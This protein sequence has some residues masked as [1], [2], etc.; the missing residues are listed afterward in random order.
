M[1]DI[2]MT[3]GMAMPLVLTRNASGG[4]NMFVRKSQ[5]QQPHILKS[6]SD[7]V[8]V[9]VPIL[10]SLHKISFKSWQDKYEAHLQRLVMSLRLAITENIAKT[11]SVEVD[12]DWQAFS[13]RVRRLA[14][15]HSTSS[16]KNIHRRGHGDGHVFAHHGAPRVHESHMNQIQSA[17]DDFAGA[18]DVEFAE[19]ML[20]TFGITD[21]HVQEESHHECE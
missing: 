19:M 13:Q 8:P 17:I 11:P 14:Y 18:N 6:I 7:Q 4:L 2:D 20:E 3:Q 1:F 21:T 5:A 15:Q 9:P 16:N 12:V 10:P